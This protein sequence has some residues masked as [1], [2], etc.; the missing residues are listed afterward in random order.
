MLVFFVSPQ[1]LQIVIFI[2]RARIALK[3]S[4]PCRSLCLGISVRGK[5]DQYNYTGTANKM[6][7]NRALQ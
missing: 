5:T 6:L 4:S 7:I 3:I 1:N 2:K